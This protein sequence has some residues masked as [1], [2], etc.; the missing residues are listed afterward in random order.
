MCGA[1]RDGEILSCVHTAVCY[2]CALFNQVKLNSFEEGVVFQGFCIEISCVTEQV[3]EG[4][5]PICFQVNMIPLGEQPKE[6][7]IAFGVNTTHEN[8]LAFQS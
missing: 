6:R 8:D 7:W 4:G 5:I 2:S 1:T 3:S